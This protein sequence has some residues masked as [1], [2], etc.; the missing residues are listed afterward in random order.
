[1]FGTYIANATRDHDWLVVAVNLVVGQTGQRGLV[2]SEVT[3]QIG[4]AEFVIECRPADGSLDHDF[5]RR[6]H[7]I[8]VRKIDFPRL[9][10][11]RNTQVGYG[12]A[13]QPGLRFGAE[14]CRALVPNLT[15]GPCRSTRKWRYRR[16]MIV[17]LYFHHNV[18]RLVAVTVL[19]RV[20]GRQEPRAAPSFNDGRVVRIGGNDAGRT[21][22]GRRLDHAEQALILRFAVDDPA[23]IEYLVPT[24]LRIRLREHH[25]FGVRCVSTESVVTVHEVVDF[26]VRQRESKVLIGL[27]Q[28]LVAILAER[29]CG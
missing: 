14:T 6:R 4:T 18:D 11:I 22:L 19:A 16:R 12:K 15:T 24:V 8:R 20:R 26:L 25:E 23:C 13:C 21:A 1:M 3:E 7:P 5:K 29:H 9:L 2:G 28:R 27:S 17:R 10:E